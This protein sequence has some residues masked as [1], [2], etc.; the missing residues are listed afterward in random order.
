M[1]K[2]LKKRYFAHVGCR[3][4]FKSPTPIKE[5]VIDRAQHGVF[6]YTRGLEKLSDSLTGWMKKGTIGRFMIS[7]LYIVLVL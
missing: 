1:K 4:G 5:A 6:G 3:Y 2:Y 7:G